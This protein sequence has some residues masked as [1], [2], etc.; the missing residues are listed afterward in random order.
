MLN[1]SKVREK[2]KTLVEMRKKLMNYI[3]IFSKTKLVFIILLLISSFLLYFPFLEKKQVEIQS[4]DKANFDI[5][6]EKK[7]ID[8]NKPSKISIFRKV[9]SP[10]NFD[11]YSLYLRSVD[12]KD[13]NCPVRLISTNATIND[14]T[15][16]VPVERFVFIDYFK[17][18]NL[19]VIFKNNS[20][21]YQF[22]SYIGKGPNEW[23]SLSAS[24]SLQ[25]YIRISTSDYIGNSLIAFLAYFGIFLLLKEY[26]KIVKKI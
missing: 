24:S 16:N 8:I 6:I 5:F 11:Y 1:K 21:N 26:Y 17:E 2:I 10:F 23:C 22:D 15:Y 9:S 14:I 19:N 7:Y 18:E 20:L 12:P 3:Q 4:E 25:G 13:H